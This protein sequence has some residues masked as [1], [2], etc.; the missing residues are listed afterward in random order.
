MR[1]A[2]LQ[3]MAEAHER[4]FGPLGGAAPGDDTDGLPQALSKAE[5][6]QK[7]DP[8]MSG[9]EAMRRAM[10]DPAILAQ[11]EKER[12]R[13]QVAPPAVV[14]LVKCEA[15]AEAIQKREGVSSAEAMRRAMKDPA[16]RDSYARETGHAERVGTLAK[17]E[18]ARALDEEAVGKRAEQ[19]ELGGMTWRS[20]WA[21]AI[22]EAGFGGGS[23]A[24]A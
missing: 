1:S 8:N 13:A 4:R 18:K 15:V 2:E 7:S 14:G 5:E 17:S 22:T 16:I 3:K 24:A 11:Y 9:A 23:A 19:L 21:Q 6:L 10:R 12:G 20:A